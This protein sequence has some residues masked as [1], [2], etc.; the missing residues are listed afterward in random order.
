M[1]ST[2]DRPVA[3]RGDEDQLYRDLARKLRGVVRMKVNTTDDIVDDAC[4]FAWMQLVRRQPQRDTVFAWLRTVAVREAVRLDRKRRAHITTELNPFE[5][6]DLSAEPDAQ[7]DLIDA[8]DTLASL[9]DQQRLTLGLHALGFHYREIGELT[10][11]TVRSVARRMFLARRA[12]RDG[13]D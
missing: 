2:T 11:A 10:G 7:D 8:R 1:A 4:G 5:H 12:I 9:R 13:R 6:P 3:L